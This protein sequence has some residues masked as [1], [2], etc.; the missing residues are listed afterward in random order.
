VPDRASSFDIDGELLQA[1]DPLDN[2]ALNTDRGIAR[3]AFGSVP[4]AAAVPLIYGQRV[5][6]QQFAE[7]LHRVQVPSLPPNSA[8]L[9]TLAGESNWCFAFVHEWSH[10]LA[11]S[12]SQK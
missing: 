12:R 10:A 7:L 4:V 5:M 3:L 1:I 6:C 9:V 2:A 11:Q 8:R